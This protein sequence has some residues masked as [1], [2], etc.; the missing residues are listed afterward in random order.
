[1]TFREELRLLLR[2]RISLIQ[3]V[4]YDEDRVVQDLLAI[5]SAEP[6]NARL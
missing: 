4:T 6:S 1:M 3:A 2:A 5:R